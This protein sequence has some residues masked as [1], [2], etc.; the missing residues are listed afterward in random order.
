MY[1]APVD[2]YKFVLDEVIGLDKLMSAT[3]H[4]EIS[5]DLVEAVLSEAGKLAADVIAPL[6][7]PGDQTGA[8]RHDDASVTTPVGF[9]DAF[10]AMAEGGWTSMEAREEFGGQ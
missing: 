3:G 7:H 8:T 4:N 2:D 9:A 5:I 1:E 10:A 6:N